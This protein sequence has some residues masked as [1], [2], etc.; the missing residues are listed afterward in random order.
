MMI[1]EHG[2]LYVCLLT[3]LVICPVKYRVIIRFVFV[4]IVL[5]HIVHG[6]A[7]IGKNC[8]VHPAIVRYIIC[9]RKVTVKCCMLV[10]KVK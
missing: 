8:S 5:A 10:G 9:Y 1:Q 3:S 7:V 4:I 6:T 2:N